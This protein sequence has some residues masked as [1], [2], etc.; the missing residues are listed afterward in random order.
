MVK[1]IV[2]ND[3]VTAICS[4][5]S[6]EN[7]IRLQFHALSALENIIRSESVEIKAE[8]KDVIASL[9]NTENEEISEKAFDLLQ[10]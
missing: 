3:G 1:E 7:S 10:D 9:A 4:L 6:S 5:F 8:V 2:A